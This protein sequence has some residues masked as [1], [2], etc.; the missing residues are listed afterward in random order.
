MA[1]K[2]DGVVVTV[3]AGA[4]L[5]LA[6]CS[7]APLASATLPQ[8]AVNIAA[9]GTQVS[10]FGLSLASAG[11]GVFVIGADGDSDALCDGGCL[12]VLK[13]DP[14]CGRSLE[15]TLF[16][17]WHHQLWRRRGGQR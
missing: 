8:L 16:R 6:V 13:T 15:R 2:T 10:A 11:D 17:E 1:L 4:I 3:L 9:P 14:E 5:V 7:I 12:F